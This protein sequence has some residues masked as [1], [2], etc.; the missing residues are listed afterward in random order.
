MTVT[1]VLAETNVRNPN[2]FEEETKGKILCAF[3]SRLVYELTGSEKELKYPESLGEKLILPDRYGD[4]YVLYLSAMICFWN[5]EYEE[6]NN[7]A[8]LF[9]SLL[10][11]YRDERHGKGGAKRFF[12]LF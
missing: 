12:N 1:E 9:A 7:H 2:A 10:Q 6:Y 3:E 5:K 11:Q 8:A 4:V